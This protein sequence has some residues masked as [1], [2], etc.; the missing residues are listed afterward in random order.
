MRK[1][2]FHLCCVKSSLEAQGSAQQRIASVNRRNNGFEGA[3]E[4]SAGVEPAN[5][6]PDTGSGNA[7]SDLI[8]REGAEAV[9][10]LLETMDKN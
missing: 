7:V 10:V 4:A 2:R 3:A 6:R 1:L 5:C 8:A 9:M